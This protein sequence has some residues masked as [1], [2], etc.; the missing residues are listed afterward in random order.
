MAGCRQIS[1]GSLSGLACGQRPDSRRGIRDARLGF[2]QNPQIRP[3]GSYLGVFF[4]LIGRTTGF[5]AELGDVQAVAFV[6]RIWH[7]SAV[8][9]RQ[10]AAISDAGVAQW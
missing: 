3:S 9:R 6:G 2:V 5:S 8:G 10:I 7:S 1:I 4:R